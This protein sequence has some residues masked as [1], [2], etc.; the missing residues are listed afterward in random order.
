MRQKLADNPELKTLLL[1]TG[2][3]VLRPDHEQGDAPPAWKYYEIYM[4]LRSELRQA[5]R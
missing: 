5:Q 3:L 1:S 4:E 2:D